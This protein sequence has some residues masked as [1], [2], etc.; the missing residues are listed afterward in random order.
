MHKV[1][2][3]N[4]SHLK[5]IDCQGNLEVHEVVE[6]FGTELKVGYSIVIDKFR[7]PYTTRT[8]GAIG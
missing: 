1:A 5:I 2:S 8:C 3:M 4:P 7:S 6:L